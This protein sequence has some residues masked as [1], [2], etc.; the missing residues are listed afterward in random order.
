MGLAE[1]PQEER[2]KHE[3]VATALGLDPTTATLMDILAAM[4]AKF[5][6]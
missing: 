4:V 3:D 1:L 2:K 5:S 6:A